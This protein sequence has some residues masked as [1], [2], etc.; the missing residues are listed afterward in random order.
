MMLLACACLTCL[1]IPRE[2]QQERPVTTIIWI[3]IECSNRTIDSQGD[4]AGVPGTTICDY[5]LSLS[6]FFLS[7]HCLL[8]FLHYNEDT[9]CAGCRRVE[10]TV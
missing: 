7:L 6:F 4:S 1:R 8:C 2:K 10:R 3:F 5:T 9:G